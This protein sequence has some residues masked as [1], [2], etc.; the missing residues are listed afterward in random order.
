MCFY[1]M[2]HYKLH[3]ACVPCRVSF[4][5]LPLDSG[6]PLCPNCGRVLVCAGHDFAPPPRRDTDAWSAVAAVLGAGLRYEGLEPCGFGK[7]PRFRPRTG[8]EVRARLAVA[9]RTGVPVAEV[10]ARRDPAVP[11]EDD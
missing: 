8:A 3:Y 7:R 11:E 1:A 10:L 4:K 9:A 2:V 6:A 5:R